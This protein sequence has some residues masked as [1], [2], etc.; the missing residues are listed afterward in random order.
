MQTP[1]IT[2]IY[3]RILDEDLLACQEG[4]S[5]AVFSR[6]MPVKAG[7]CDDAL[8]EKATLHRVASE[9]CGSHEMVAGTGKL[10]ALKRLS[11]GGK[12]KW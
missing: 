7:A 3:L 5:G 1:H 11:S 8:L 2:R 9:R 12:I 6:L 4:S 10:A